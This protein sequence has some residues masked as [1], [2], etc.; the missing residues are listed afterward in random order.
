MV[1]GELKIVL[2][3]NSPGPPQNQT[4]EPKTRNANDAPGT[5]RVFWMSATVE[6]VERSDPASDQAFLFAGL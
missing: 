4:Q 6:P 2:G 1:G 5:A 3:E